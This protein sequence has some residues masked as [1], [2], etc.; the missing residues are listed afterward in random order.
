LV[1]NLLAGVV[2]P[3]S[4]TGVDDHIAEV[5]VILVTSRNYDRLGAER[6]SSADRR[7]SRAMDLSELRFTPVGEVATH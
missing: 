6:T 4:M 1:S 3:A 7:L 5:L 2:V